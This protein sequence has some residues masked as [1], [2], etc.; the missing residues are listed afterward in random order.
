VALIEDSFQSGL[1]L[2]WAVSLPLFFP[3]S[4]PFFSDFDS[5]RRSS[6]FMDQQ[7]FSR[8]RQLPIFFFPGFSLFS[9]M[10]DRFVKGRFDIPF[11]GTPLSPLKKK[12]APGSF[13]GD[14][15]PGSSDPEA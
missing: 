4:T 14:Q 8:V 11:P 12:T 15:P 5:S 9:D 1:P 2:S 10:K 7:E 6:L 13:L 3:E